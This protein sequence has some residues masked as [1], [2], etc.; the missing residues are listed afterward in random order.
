[1]A[2]QKITA[3]TAITAATTDD[4]LYI[5]DDPAGTAVSKKIT[6]DNVQ[7]SLT[8]VGK[9]TVTQ[10]ATSATLTIPDG[11]TLTGPAV[12]GTAS[13]L[14]GTETLSNKT[15]TTPDIG[16]ATATSVN[17]VAFTAP[18]TSATLTLVDG[19]TVT[20]PA[21]TGT[22]ATLA[23][24]ET[25]SNKTLT[26][27]DI[28]TPSAG[29]LTNCSGTAASLTAGNVTTNANLTGPITSVGNAT[30]VNA[31]TTGGN[32]TLAENTSIVLD[33]V[34]SADGKYTG[35]TIAGTA[36]AA[37]VFGDLVYLAV[38]DSRWELTDADAD[39]TAGAVM[40]GMCVLAASADGDPTTVLLQGNIRADA[41]FPALT[42]G[43][44][45]YVG[46]TAG[47]IQV[48]KPS[49]TDDVVR[50]VGHAITADSIRFNPSSDWATVI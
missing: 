44:P 39:A 42:V 50:V 48:A 14:A 43:A 3:L 11:V 7:L 31:F 34:L 28:G 26:T 35:T 8:K 16:V 41:K 24:S 23:G 19:T 9:I 18:A 38:A 6:F 46:I 32:I 10:P 36:G 40:V 2:N 45:V 49:G 1:M 37:L 20:G 47:E 15:L 21:T 27:P 17:K 4:I 33:P 5:V 29:V 22:I 12:S 30:T 13:T 25:L